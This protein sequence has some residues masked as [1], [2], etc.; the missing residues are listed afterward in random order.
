MHVQ[1]PAPSLEEDHEISL[2]FRQDDSTGEKEDMGRTRTGHEDRHVGWGGSVLL[3]L[4]GLGEPGL[5]RKDEGDP[6]RGTVWLVGVMD[7]FHLE[8]GTY[9]PII[10]YR[11]DR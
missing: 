11:S 10:L 2:G 9:Q 7:H 5:K 8:H 1:R 3:L 4:G 6:E